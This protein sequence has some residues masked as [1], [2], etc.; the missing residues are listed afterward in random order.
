MLFYVQRWNRA[1]RQNGRRMFGTF[2]AVQRWNQIYFLM[3]NLGFV[4][5][6]T[7][8]FYNFTVIMVF[9]NCCVNP[10]IYTVKYEQVRTGSTLTLLLA[11]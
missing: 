6:F 9:V 4:V 7:S 11:V 2:Y 3:H 1:C 5:D 10:I 8:S